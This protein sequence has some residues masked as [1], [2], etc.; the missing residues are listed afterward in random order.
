M[1]KIKTEFM[2]NKYFF[3]ENRVIYEIM[4]KNIIESD[5]PQ[6]TIWR[7]RFACW[8]LKAIHTHSEYVMLIAFPLQQWLRKRAS[9]LR[10]TY[11]GCLVL[12]TGLIH[13]PVGEC[14]NLFHMQGLP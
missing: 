5:R 4:W 11:I 2:F 9:M 13:Y 10:H 14:R 8:I 6:I 3:I 1:E 12:V 7:M